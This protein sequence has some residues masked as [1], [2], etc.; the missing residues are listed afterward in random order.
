MNP[1]GKIPVIKDGS[2]VLNESAAIVTYLFERYG[3]E[4]SIGQQ[5]RAKRDALNYFI[6]TEI[7][8]Q[9]LYIH[10][11]HVGLASIYGE[12]PQAVKSAEKYYSKQ[13]GVIVGH[14]ESQGTT[15]LM[16]GKLS[17]PDILF[18]HCLFWGAMIGWNTLQ[19]QKIVQY[20]R[21]LVNRPAFQRAYSNLP[22]YAQIMAS[23]RAA[24]L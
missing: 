2:F 24:K 15:F 10:R 4:Q 5:A 18:G 11:K 23:V 12:A 14:L 16:G 3:A 21:A 13:V 19:N 1:A 22:P 17:P 6:M 7:D 9:S 20:M 8:A